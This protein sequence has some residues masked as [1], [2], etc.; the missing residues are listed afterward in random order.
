M[1]KTTCYPET[2]LVRLPVTGVANKK[3]MKLRARA[4]RGD[5]ANIRTDGAKVHDILMAQFRFCADDWKERPMKVNINAYKPWY[6]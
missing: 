6:N 3:K 5:S 4:R 1:G 2:R